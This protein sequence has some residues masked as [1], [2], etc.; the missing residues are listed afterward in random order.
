TPEQLARIEDMRKRIEEIWGGLERLMKTLRG[1]YIQVTDA[2][3]RDECGSMEKGIED[4]KKAVTRKELE[5]T[6]QLTQVL[7]WIGELEPLVNKC[8]TR[9][10]LGKK[11]LIL[12]GT[13]LHDDVQMLP[14]DASVNVFGHQVGG[15]QLVK[16]T[17]PNK[18]AVVNGKM[19]RIGDIVEG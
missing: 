10:E 19:Y 5:E 17:K 3:N 15:T 11:K 1:I 14:L 2:F 9:I 6:P 7:K 13:M 8:K 18:I 12:T 16:F 4:L